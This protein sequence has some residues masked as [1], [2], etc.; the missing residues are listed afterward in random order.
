VFAVTL[1]GLGARAAI[2][3]YAGMALAGLG[4]LLALRARA[5]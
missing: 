1:D 2:A 3:L 4:A 5:D